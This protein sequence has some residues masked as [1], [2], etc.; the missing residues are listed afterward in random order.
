MTVARAAAK[1]VV[2]LA[3]INSIVAKVAPNRVVTTLAIQNIVAVLAVKLVVSAIAIE[4]IAATAAPNRVVTT[5]AAQD[6]A[7]CPATDLVVTVTAPER[8]V[9]PIT[10][11]LIIA[12]A[13]E[14]L[15]PVT[16]TGGVD[17]DRCLVAEL[18]LPRATHES[19]YFDLSIGEGV[20]VFGSLPLED[21]QSAAHLAGDRGAAAVFTF[22]TDHAIFESHFGLG[23]V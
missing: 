23:R 17:R 9:S 3:T 4:S 19:N 15:I 5:L 2:S 13:T 18:V 6:I 8:V 10:I 22:D 11:Q 14:Q 21:V 16:T 12:V 7:A 1:V 20:D